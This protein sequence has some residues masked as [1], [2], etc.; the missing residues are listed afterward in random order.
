MT[1]VVYCGLLGGVTVVQLKVDGG[2]TEHAQFAP[3]HKGNWTP[4][5]T[6][7]KKHKLVELVPYTS[8]ACAQL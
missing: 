4:V 7:K 8:Q 1:G 5:Y 6:F 3:R 2:G